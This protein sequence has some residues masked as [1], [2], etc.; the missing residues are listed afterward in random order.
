MSRVYSQQREAFQVRR[1]RKRI[2][3]KP[4]PCGAQD[5]P[6]GGVAP[7]VPGLRAQ[8]QSAQQLEDALIDPY[9]HKTV[10]LRLLRKSFPKKLR[11]PQA[12]AD[13]QFRP[14]AQLRPTGDF[15]VMCHCH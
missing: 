11:P 15:L 13:P 14:R 1:M 8:F 3:P 7:Q 5:S 4:Y 12:L 9:G 6:H 2:L 10:S